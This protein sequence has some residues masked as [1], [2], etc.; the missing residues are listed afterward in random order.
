MFTINLFGSKITFLIG[1]EVSV[2]FFQGAESE[3]SQGEFYEFTVPMFGQE[4]GHGVD[5]ATRNEQN[6]FCI[7]ALKTSKLRSYVDPMLQEVEVD[8]YSE[9]RFGR[10]CLMSSTHCFMKSKIALA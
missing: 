3:I 10:R 5:F 1:P 6:S 7:D 9:K 4:V 2:H 8:A